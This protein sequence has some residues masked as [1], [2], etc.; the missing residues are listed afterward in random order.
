[1]NLR[2]NYFLKLI[3]Y[4]NIVYH[5]DKQIEYITDKRLN[6]TYKTSEII[7]PVLTG[8]LVRVQSFNQLKCMIK[9]GE[10]EEVH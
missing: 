6:P 3:K 5:L 4:I 1:M 9:F 10:F 2:E 8:L 7:S